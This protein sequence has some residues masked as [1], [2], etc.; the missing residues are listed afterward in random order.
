MV[1]VRFY[2][3]QGPFTL[4]EIAQWTGAVIRLPSIPAFK[5]VPF[6]DVAAL[7]KATDRD[8]AF[9][10]NTKYTD[11]F[12]ASKAGACFVR[13]KYANGAPQGMTL[14]LSEDPYR[15]YAITAQKFYPTLPYKSDISKQAHIDP[16]ASFGKGCSVAAGAHIGARVTVGDNTHIGA[17]VV[18]D[19]GVCIGSNCFIGAGSTLSH[20]IIANHVIIHRNVNIGQDGFGFAMG[21]EG[22]IKVPQLGRVIIDDN[23]EIG[24]GTCIDRGTGPDTSIGAGTKID[25]LVQ[26]GHNVQIGKNAIIV[27]Q[28]GI[29][30]STRIGDGAVLG[31]QVG[32]AGHLR[33]GAGSKLAAKAGVMNDIPNGAAFGGTPAVPIKDW[34]RQSIVLAKLSQKRKIEDD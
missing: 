26:I 1:D 17:N 10:D 7:D 21:R 32:V 2:Q 28:V 4:S 5:S 30:G 24:S 15:C 9:L 29:S 18:L 25:N 34:H 33:I 20:C 13:E 14:L 22:H 3:R 19:D 27:S 16:T 31:G 23:V 11:N 12:Y 6:I 8:I